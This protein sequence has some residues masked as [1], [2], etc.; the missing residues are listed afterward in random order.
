MEGQKVIL[1]T[2]N[3]NAYSGLEGAGMMRRAYPPTVRPIRVPCLSRL[4]PGMIL[5]AFE[6]GASG[7]MLMGCVP[8]Q[9]HYDF[10]ARKTEAV[11]DQAKAL[12]GLLGYEKTR[13]QLDYV[14]AGD[15]TAVAE[16]VCRFINRRNRNRP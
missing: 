5:K 2:C 11:F 16:T 7:V 8:E 10:G 6:Q 4:H 9:C 14:Q 15:G 3:W 13:L 12:I 1:F